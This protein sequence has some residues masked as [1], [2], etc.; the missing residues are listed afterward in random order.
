MAA[1]RMSVCEIT[2]GQRFKNGRAGVSESGHYGAVKAG[3]GGD[4]DAA[5]LLNRIEISRHLL[6]HLSCEKNQCFGNFSAASML[7]LT[8]AVSP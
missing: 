4:K 1:C 6:L 7:A 8:M 3:T 5:E 2:A